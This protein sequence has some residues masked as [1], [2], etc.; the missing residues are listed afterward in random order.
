MKHFY[1]LLLFFWFV[2]LT[3]LNLTAENI[4]LGK[5]Y[6]LE[7][8]PDYTH[9]TDADDLK[10][11]TDGKYVKEYFWT[12]QGTEV[13]PGKSPVIITIDLGLICLISG[14]SFIRLQA[15]PMKFS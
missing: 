11:L 5:A 8:I 1:P 10:Q 9:C 7:P 2:L 15:Q 13:G 6:T 14:V 4:A 12:Q 3:S